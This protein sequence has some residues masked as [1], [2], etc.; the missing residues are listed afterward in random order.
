LISVQEMMRSPHVMQKRYLNVSAPLALAELIRNNHAAQKYYPI[1]SFGR[2]T[3]EESRYKEIT[4]RYIPY[5]ADQLKQGFLENNTNKIQTYILALGMTGHEKILSVFEPYLEGT[6]PTSKFHRLLIVASMST[7]ARLQP[8]LVGPILFK[9]YSNLNEAQE[10]RA[11]A[12]QQ[13]IMTNPS[14]IAL[15]TV[16]RRTNIDSSE[17]VNSVVRTMLESIANT[18]RPEL[19]NLALKARNAR[20]LLNPNKYDSWKNSRSFYLELEGLLKGLNLQYIVGDDSRPMYARLSIHTLYDLLGL[21]SLEVGYAVSN[22]KQLYDQLKE[23]WGESEKT[24]ELKQKLNVENIAQ[25]LKIKPELLNKLEGNIFINTIYGLM[26]QSFDS[27]AIK[28]ASYREYSESY[29]KIILLL[30]I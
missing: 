18:R 9:L 2:I 1:H 3:L 11:L 20:Y 15:Q 4:N 24:E 30:K 12:V 25:A 22:Y 27:Q 6:E 7:L 29:F 8:K 23:E 16:A 28:R 21:P 26:F 14:A 17:Q 5:L 19:R 13:F 10:I